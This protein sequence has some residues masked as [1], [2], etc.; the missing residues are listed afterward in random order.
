MAV[1]NLQLF[2]GA[3]HAMAFDAAD[4]ADG[5]RHVDAGNIGTGRGKSADQAGAGIRRAADDLHR[6]VGADIDHQHL[7][8]VGLRMLFGRQDLGDDEG[9]ER[10]LVVDGIDFEA[11]LGQAGADLIKTSLGVEVIFQPGEC[12]FH[13][14]SFIIKSMKCAEYQP[15]YAALPGASA[16]GAFMPRNMLF[17]EMPSSIAVHQMPSYINSISFRS[18][19]LRP[20]RK[21][22]HQTGVAITRPSARATWISPSAHQA[23]VGRISSVS[24][25]KEVIPDAYPLFTML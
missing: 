1:G 23:R 4:I 15:A 22:Y 17:T 24:K 5:Q 12:E 13:W 18:L 9:L 19:S 3:H 7:Q 11:D 14:S 21:G 6:L 16:P 8:P 2:F 10:R 25:T 20:K